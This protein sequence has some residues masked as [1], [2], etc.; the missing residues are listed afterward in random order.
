MAA[1]LASASY[2]LGSTTFAAGHVHSTYH[3]IFLR[4]CS[5][6][7]IMSAGKPIGWPD[8][9]NEALSFSESSLKNVAEPCRRCEMALA[10]GLETNARARD[11]KL[12]VAVLAKVLAWHCD[13]DEVQEW[14]L[15]FVYK[16]CMCKGPGQH[17][18]R[19]KF[20]TAIST[21]VA[22]LTSHRHAAVGA[23]LLKVLELGDNHQAL[24]SML[25]ADR[26]NALMRLFER[27]LLAPVAAAAR[28]AAKL[29]P[30]TEF[31]SRVINYGEHVGRE[32]DSKSLHFND[33]FS[34]VLVGLEQQTSACDHK[35]CL[36]RTLV[37]AVFRQPHRRPQCVTT[38]GNFVDAAHLSAG[39][40]HHSN[41]FAQR[42]SM[43]A[44]VVSN[45]RQMSWGTRS[46]SVEALN[47]VVRACRKPLDAVLKAPTSSNSRLAISTATCRALAVLA[48][49]PF[50]L[51]RRTVPNM[52][53]ETWNIMMTELPNAGERIVLRE[54]FWGGKEM[55]NL[56]ETAMKSGIT[57]LPLNDARRNEVAKLY[58]LRCRA[59]DRMLE[60]I[61]KTAA[62]RF[63]WTIS[64]VVALFT[65]DSHPAAWAALIAEWANFYY[66]PAG[67]VENVPASL[68][69]YTLPWQSRNSAVARLLAAANFFVSHPRTAMALFK[70]N[71]G[72]WP[73]AANGPGA[74][75]TMPELTPSARRA[76]A[77]HRPGC[78]GFVDAVS[79][80]RFAPTTKVPRLF[81]SGTLGPMCFLGC[82]FGAAARSMW[83][84]VVKRGVGAERVHLPNELYVMILNLMAAQCLCIETK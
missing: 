6:L 44:A 5:E 75:R 7:L 2:P 36:V 39:C 62:G 73:N 50:E 69:A 22:W 67:V 32:G 37:R 16:N 27:C 56:M 34:T 19:V 68:E 45:A 14:L 79:A 72:M 52:S 18:I 4:K 23:R 25:W 10:A 33:I 47:D 29:R 31:D 43:L 24:L 66:R 46:T 63:M 60:R 59:A 83:I 35:Y 55:L 8:F 15:S 80:K 9:L 40:P 28:A 74:P 48:A 82:G 54:S 21:E 20:A 61:A 1:V 57:A 81:C 12:S 65:A 70:G 84:C 13:N 49:H 3:E 17:R 26:N 38:L 11:R 64:V 51:P 53:P 58:A 41:T 30:A 71:V 42:T 78:L 77:T 76:L